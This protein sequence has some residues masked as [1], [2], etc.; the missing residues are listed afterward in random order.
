MSPAR[1]YHHGDLRNAV[2]QAAL[3]VLATAGPAALSLRQVAAQAGVSHTA[4]RHHFGDKQRLLTELAVE[5][6]EELAAAMTAEL[7]RSRQPSRD[8]VDE[9]AALLRAYVRHRRDQ[10]GY[11]AVMWRTDLLDASDP[12][13]R[14]ASLHTFEVLHR[15]V[16]RVDAPAAD[17]LG[18]YR[19]ALLFWSLAQGVSDLADRL[20]PALA[21]A[22]GDADPELPRPEELIVEFVAALGDGGSATQG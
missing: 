5:G 3:Q 19:L 1:G 17:R 16:R 22:V 6:F 15:A 12:R 21:A 18:A 14:Q 8:P 4:P 10:P 9:V 7:G 20:T 13:L 2:K 11:A